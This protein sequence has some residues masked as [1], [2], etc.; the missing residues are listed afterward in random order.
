MSLVAN[1]AGRRY[2]M[3]FVGLLSTLALTLGA[4]GASAETFEG[5]LAAKEWSCGKCSVENPLK[6]IEAEIISQTGGELCVGPVQYYS[7]KYHFPYGWQCGG[8]GS[9]WDF[10]AIEAAEGIDNPNSF[11]VRYRGEAH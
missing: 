9:A 2:V 5:K 4:S 11:S 8:W 3:L 6:Y 1:R 7:G 10:T